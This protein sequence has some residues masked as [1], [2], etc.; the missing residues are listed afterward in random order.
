[1]TVSEFANKYSLKPLTRIADR[2]I[3]CGFC[4]DL[5]SRAMGYC[6]EN[7]AWFTVMGNINAIAVAS[8]KDVACI[9]LCRGGAVQPDA[10]EK[11][12]EEGINILSS[13]AP[14]WELAGRLYMDLKG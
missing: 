10:L 5:L 12:G 1:M 11:A 14:A 2:Q 8:L 6:P 9:V 7:S 13:S 3:D 4:G